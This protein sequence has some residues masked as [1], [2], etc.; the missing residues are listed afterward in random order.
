[1]W[2]EGPKFISDGLCTIIL[3]PG[4]SAIRFTINFNISTRLEEGATRR[5]RLNC[6]IHAI[7]MYWSKTKTI[8]SKK[9]KQFFKTCLFFNLALNC[10]DVMEALISHNLAEAL[11]FSLD[12]SYTTGIDT[13]FT[14]TK[15]EKIFS[16]QCLLTNI[17]Y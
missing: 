16:N 13:S 12:L 1:M 4:L 8:Q 10:V 15:V 2:M 11:I 17:S 9:P 6:S 14:K 7:K 3:K 5:R